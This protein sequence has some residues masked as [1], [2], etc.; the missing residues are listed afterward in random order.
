MRTHIGGDDPILGFYPG[1]A[2]HL[3]SAMKRK[4]SGNIAG[5][6]TDPDRFFYILQGVALAIA[7]AALIWI[8]PTSKSS[9]VQTVIQMETASEPQGKEPAVASPTPSAS[10]MQKRAEQKNGREKRH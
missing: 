2:H 6:F 4:S 1:I 9:D 5:W 3:H 8:G 7:M 10:Q